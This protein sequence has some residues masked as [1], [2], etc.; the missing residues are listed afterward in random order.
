MRHGNEG[1]RWFGG[2]A[3][4]AGV[5]VA[6]GCGSATEDTTAAV[7]Q[8]VESA[9]DSSDAVEVSNLMRG[10]RALRPQAVEGF[11]CDPSPDITHVEVCGKTLP[12]SIQLSWTDCAAPQR[13]AG[14]GRPAGLPPPPRGGGTGGTPPP[15]ADGGTR[16][17][18][19]GEG[20]GPAH[21]GPS[22]G[23]V[24]ITYLY[25]AAEDCSGPITQ[26]QSVTFQIS[27]TAED[28]SVS[29]V[30]GNTASSAELVGD[31]PPRQKQT[32]ADVT[33][34]LTDASGVVVRSVHLTGAVSVEF[35]SDTP[36]TRTINGSYTEE[37][38]DGSRGTVTLQNIVRP[39]R[40]VCPW[41]TSGTLSRATS[42]GQT[43]ALVFG[44]ECGAATLDGTAVELSG[45][46]GPGQGGPRQGRR[47]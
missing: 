28:G 9:S 37:Q 4:I 30:Q 36:P 14:G 16:P 3:L 21:S 18:R 5:L 7:S 43:H 42:A 1:S 38:L 10:L 25:S 31:A 8:A 44:P 41:P 32:N 12:A 11:H 40:S 24:S 45:Q 33:R 19:G 6:A 22:S 46:G 20:C 29:T 26:D 23:T 2:I 27:R 39:A 35:S 15:S 47:R 34:T 17:P 13:P